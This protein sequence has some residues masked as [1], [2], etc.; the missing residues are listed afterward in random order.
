M[1]CLI[2]TSV[3]CFFISAGL[4]SS[5]K[6]ILNASVV[7]AFSMVHHPL[8]LLLCVISLLS[9]SATAG[10]IDV[11]YYR[12]C[13]P[14]EF[15]PFLVNSCQILL[16][17]FSYFADHVIGQF[18]DHVS[19]SYHICERSPMRLPMIMHCGIFFIDSIIIS[20]I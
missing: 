4:S 15:F 1:P 2:C 6:G 18:R 17:L 16:E 13:T 10:G 3:L 11:T 12:M 14:D 5:G 9:F 8:S 20:G 7:R 19:E